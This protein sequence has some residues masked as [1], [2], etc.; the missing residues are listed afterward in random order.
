M[1]KQSIS[2][3]LLILLIQ[4]VVQGEN[5]TSYYNKGVEFFKTGNLLEAE[6]NFKQAVKVNPAYSLGH[7]G[8]GR[9]YILQNEKIKDAIKHFKLSVSLD[10]NFAMGWFKLGLAELI[11]GKYIDSLHSFDKAYEMD[12]T[13]IESLYNMGTV[14]DLLGDEYK[15]FAYYRLYYRQ[16]KGEGGIKF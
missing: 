6:N 9:I 16:V 11:A 13:L 12:D 3:I 7:Y 1:L 14:Y 5:S 8:L 10:P 2:I 4:T 15:A